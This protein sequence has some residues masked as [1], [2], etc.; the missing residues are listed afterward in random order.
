MAGYMT[1]MYGNLYEGEFVNGAS[2]PVANGTL[3]VL[4]PT[5]MKLV[6]PAADTTSR[7]VCK[8]ITT[9]FDG[10]PA[11]RIVVDTIAAGKRYY[12]VE[13]GADIDGSAEY[14]TAEYAVPVG[15]FVRA[16]PLQVNDE[17]VA[18]TDSTLRVGT[19]YGV[20]AT[21]TIG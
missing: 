10:V 18:T 14:D 1:K 9:I 6:L 4:N 5:T 11:Y 20:K 3:M 7:F 19:S 16:H 17:F 21:G 2:A 15:A 8:E 12:L 13:N